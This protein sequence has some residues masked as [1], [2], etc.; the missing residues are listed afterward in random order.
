LANINDL[1]EE[2]ARIIG[3]QAIPEIKPEFTIMP[4]KENKLTQL[5]SSLRNYL[6]DY[7]FHQVKTYNLTSTSSLNDFNFFNY[8]KPITLLAPMSVSRKVMRYSLIPSLLEIC[9][10]NASYKQ[11]ALKVFTDEV[12]YTQDSDEYDYHFAFVVN[13]NFFSDKIKTENGYLLVKGFLEA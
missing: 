6:L 5:L 4:I 3:Y 10:L 1:T 11:D 9:R 2:V 7:G 13:N 8:H 12:I